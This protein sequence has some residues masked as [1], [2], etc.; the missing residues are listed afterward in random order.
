MLNNT[1]H[2]NVPWTTSTTSPSPQPKGSTM[3]A[4]CLPTATIRPGGR[5]GLSTFRTEEIFEIPNSGGNHSSPF[6]TRKHGIPG[7]RH[8]LQCAHGRQQRRSH[9]FYKE[10]FKGSISFIKVNQETGRMNIEFSIAHAWLQLRPEPRRQRPHGWFFFSTYNTER[11]H[12]LL[13][14]N[15]SQN[16]KDFIMAVNWKKAEEY[17]AQGKAKVEKSKIRP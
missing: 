9:Q 4:G 13:E 15:A 12:T 14:V 1:S 6:I 8:P 5:V 10:N 17:L 7:G 16:D 11:A 3:D 2:G